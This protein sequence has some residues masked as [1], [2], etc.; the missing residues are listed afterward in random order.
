[1]K[2]DKIMKPRDGVAIR[3]AELSNEKIETF[4]N[5]GYSE[6]TGA[7]NLHFEILDQKTDMN[8]KIDLCDFSYPSECDMITFVYSIL[9]D[10]VNTTELD[11]TMIRIFEDIEE[12]EATGTM[13][14]RER[15]AYKEFV[16]LM[17]KFIVGRGNADLF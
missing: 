3:F 9:E 12:S 7:I 15:D 14:L 13:M 10:F 5:C 17:H 16:T 6:E 4:L 11:I 8:L 2:G 1:M